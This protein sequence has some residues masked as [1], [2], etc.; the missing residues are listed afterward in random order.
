MN[1]LEFKLSFLP[2]EDYVAD[3]LAAELGSIGF[4][5]FER[6]EEGL[7]AFIDQNCFNETDFSN[8]LDGFEYAES[9]RFE[10]REIEQVNWNEEWEKHFFEPIIIGDECLIHSSFRKNLPGAKYDIVI[11]PKMSFGTGH[12]ETTS[13]MIGEILQMDL[14]GKTVLDMGCGTAILAVLAA[15]KGARQVTAIDIDTWCVENSIENIERNKVPDIEVLLGNADLLAGKSFNIIIANINRNILLN[16]IK[17]Y[18][19]CLGKGDALYMSGFYVDDIPVI[20][21]EAARYNI[22]LVSYKEK[23]NWAVVKMT[24]TQ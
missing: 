7:T 17:K 10:S 15:K 3:L 9:V 14:N 2:D 22:T 21:Q 4:E 8:L 23:N 1:Y 5:S 18:A 20:E 6:T 12:H 11:D 16:D 13:L 24:K 19:A